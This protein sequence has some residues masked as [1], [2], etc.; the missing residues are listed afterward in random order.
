[1]NS[2][3]APAW[4]EHVEPGNVAGVPT[5]AVIV[6]A[7]ARTAL[8]L[9]LPQTAFMLRAGFAAM[10]EGAFVDG[11][12]EPLTMCYDRTI[13][14]HVLG[15]ERLLAL[16]RPA[17]DEALTPIL[18]ALSASPI[19]AR[20]LLSFDE[21]L[22]DPHE[23]QQLAQDA[24]AAVLR[25]VEQSFAG[26]RLDLTLCGN[27]GAALS[28][29][30]ALASL[31]RG[32][33]DLLLVG[34]VHSDCHVPRLAALAEADR[35]LAADNVDALT[36][37]EA[38]AFVAVVSAEL[39][40]RLRLGVIA[41]LCEVGTGSEPARPDN[42]LPIAT[43]R[44]LTAAVHEA[45][46]PL[47]EKG[48]RA[49]WLLSDMT[50]EMWRITEWQSVLV[51]GRGVLGDPYRVDSPAAQLGSLG[52]AAGPLGLALACHGFESGWAP[53]EGALV[54]TSSDGGERGAVLLAAGE[55]SAYGKGAAP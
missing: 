24:A 37:G 1:M 29:A 15:A 43:A 30:S 46:A 4:A 2:P 7:G 49:G 48:A 10:A 12:G 13:A 28:L 41:R 34:G 18:A 14:P 25:H 53:A 21:P 11:A 50:G 22:G 26:A 3:A 33:T 36:P 5:R 27:A 45:T 40:R 17:I 54:L 20:L 8:G 9:D 32:E 44:G 51:R 23:A 38:S 16:A 31:E 6:S 19:R 42:D 39:A 52:A 47:L 35:L 55:A